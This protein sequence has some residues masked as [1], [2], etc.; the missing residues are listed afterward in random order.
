MTILQLE[1]CSLISQPL[2][3]NSLLS[4]DSVAIVGE[5]GF[6]YFSL[7]NLTG[8]VQMVKKA[9]FMEIARPVL[10]VHQA[11]P[12]FAHEHKIKNEKKKIL[13]AKFV[14]S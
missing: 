10:L 2:N 12:K 11:I 7:G 13:F 1:M 5:T 14:M 4:E 9:T 6:V 3:H 8:I